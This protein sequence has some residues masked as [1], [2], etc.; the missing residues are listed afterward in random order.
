MGHPALRRVSG[1]APPG[2]LP[3][4]E[5]ETTIRRPGGSF[6]PPPTTPTMPQER[7]TAAHSPNATHARAAR[8]RPVLGDDDKAC[9]HDEL[10][11][12][13]GWLAQRA[14]REAR[15]HRSHVGPRCRDLVLVELAAGT[16]LRASELARLRVCDVHLA[17]RAPYVRVVGG[18]AREK[19]AVD[20]VP[21]PAALLARLRA[22][23]G[24]RERAAGARAP[25][26]VTP[27]T[28]RAMTR[29]EVWRAVK[30]AVRAAGARD[31]LSTHSLRH[32]FVSAASRSPRANP[33]LVAKLARLRSL[34]LVD[35][36]FHAARE[37]KRAVVDS[38]K[39][40][41]RRQP[42]APQR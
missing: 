37:D 18:K 29:K 36:Y 20:T 9:T 16:G 8:G 35:T 40:P 10:G 5:N 28:D 22:F 25:V 21:L 23:V 11:R 15:R 41:R 17:G 27:R 38:I 1:V 24:E 32:F 14:D 31:V 3:G 6:L 4:R 42:A 19:K 30:A 7:Q 34:A 13:L 39:L 2:T 12:M 33:L 26:F